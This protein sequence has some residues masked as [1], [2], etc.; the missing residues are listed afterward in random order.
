MNIKENITNLIFKT[1]LSMY[2]ISKATGVSEQV[3][4]KYKNGDSRIDNMPLE[5]ALKLNSF[6]ESLNVEVGSTTLKTYK[7]LK[8]HNGYD[9]D[10]LDAK[11]K[12]VEGFKTYLLDNKM[13]GLHFIW[14]V[15]HTD[16]SVQN[17]VEI[18][19]VG[20]F[21]NEYGVN[22]EYVDGYGLYYV[23]DDLDN[24]YYINSL[25]GY[26]QFKTENARKGYGD[27]SSLDSFIEWYVEKPKII[28]K[29]FKKY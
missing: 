1:D 15:Q 2:K 17:V 24:V 28:K 19:E 18:V 8:D 29:F 25:Y 13:Y 10:D 14:T 6:Y 11:I 12:S 16:F 7:W 23:S 20:T 9:N 26:D 3:L 4:G 5:T 27:L 22:T 21:E